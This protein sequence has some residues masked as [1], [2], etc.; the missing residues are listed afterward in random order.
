MYGVLTLVI[1]Q[2]QGDWETQY[3]CLILYHKHIIDMIKQFA[4]ID[5]NHLSREENQMA[6]ALATLSAMF[7]VS[8]SDEVQPI[9]MRLQKTPAHYVYIKKKMDEKPWYYDIQRY[10]KEQQYPEHTSKNDKRILRRLAT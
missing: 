4:E 5:F 9:R 7:Q 8:S 3:S 6:D 1:Y 2:L 10:V